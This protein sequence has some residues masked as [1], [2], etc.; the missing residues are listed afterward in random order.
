MEVDR[1]KPAGLDHGAGEI[2]VQ[3]LGE[4]AVRLAWCCTLV[5]EQAVLEAGSSVQAHR[6]RPDKPRCVAAGPFGALPHIDYRPPPRASPAMAASNCSLREPDCSW[7]LSRV[8]SGCNDRS[9]LPIEL[10][11]NVAHNPPAEAE[12]KGLTQSLSG[13]RSLAA[14]CVGPAS[15]AGP[16]A[17]RL[18]AATRVEARSVGPASRAACRSARGSYPRAP[19]PLGCPPHSLFRWLSDAPLRLGVRFDL[20][21]EAAN[22]FELTLDGA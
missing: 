4:S 5:P 21:P 8:V 22:Y 16:S 2:G 12:E 9:S 13:K 17:A 10:M 19:L 6:R 7:C 18:A 15:R 14:S 11:P 20:A 1:K 3:S